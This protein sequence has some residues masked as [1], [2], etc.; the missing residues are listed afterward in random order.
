MKEDG[1]E[2]QREYWEEQVTCVRSTANHKSI[3]LSKVVLLME[4]Q[5]FPIGCLSEY[6]VLWSIPSSLKLFST[7]W[8]T[9]TNNVFQ[10]CLAVTC[11][12]HLVLT[13]T[14]LVVR[15]TQTLHEPQ[16]THSLALFLNLPNAM[17]VPVANQLLP[18][19][20]KHHRRSGEAH[21]T[22]LQRK[23]YFVSGGYV[24]LTS[25][26]QIIFCKLG[27]NY[28][29]QNMGHKG[30]FFEQ[31]NRWPLFSEGRDRLSSHCLKPE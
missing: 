5:G 18:V 13:K 10:Q 17:D 8:R 25:W 7:H 20:M 29:H 1:S 12:L 4:P 14:T 27:S 6:G 22:V 23:G 28:N 16:L 19:E 24:Y 26:W 11:R 3:L 15:S 2:R 21:Q 9:Y 31:L 30:T